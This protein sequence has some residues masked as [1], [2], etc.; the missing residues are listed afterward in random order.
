MSEFSTDKDQWSLSH[1]GG[2]QPSFRVGP[3]PDCERQVLVERKI[4]DDAL[5]EACLHCGHRFEPET[6]LWVSLRKIAD[7]GYAV[8]GIDEADECDTHGGCRDGECGVQ[9]PIG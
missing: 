8:D 9:Q 3:C 6:L 7:L 2:E 4:G 5:I 1:G